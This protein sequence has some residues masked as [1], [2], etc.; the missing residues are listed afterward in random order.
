M[1]KWTKTACVAVAG[2]V[3]PFIS[4]AQ[5]LVDEMNGL[6]SVLD[7]LYDEMM[8]LCSKLIGVG[9]GIAG[10]AATWYIASRIWRHIIKSVCVSYECDD[11]RCGA[12]S[13]C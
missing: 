2:I 4:R 10:F 1:A 13:R 7:Q 5:G 11:Q 3:L 6:H 8:P 9:Q 12:R